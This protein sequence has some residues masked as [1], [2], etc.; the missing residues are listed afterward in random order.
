MI[1]LHIRDGKRWIPLT[2]PA[3]PKAGGPADTN[4]EVNAVFLRVIEAV[5][6]GT[7]D[8]LMSL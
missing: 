1:T 4:L 5:K 2:Q 3:K 7:E 6:W 8:T